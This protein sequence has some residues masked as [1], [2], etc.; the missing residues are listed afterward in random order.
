MLNAQSFSNKKNLL[1][2]QYLFIG[3]IERYLKHSFIIQVAEWLCLNCQM[4]RAHNNAPVVP[5]KISAQ[6]QS[7]TKAGI[8][9]SLHQKDACSIDSTKNITNPLTAAPQTD[10][11]SEVIKK[12]EQQQINAPHDSPTSHKRQQ[13][14]SLKPQG[15]TL[16]MDKSGTKNQSGFFGFD[17]ARSRSP[18]PKPAA[19]AVTEKVL[20]F[21]T[22]FL[23]SASNMISSAV[24]DE[25]STTP[26][27]SRK[28]LSVSQSSV[29]SATP[30]SSRKG[31]AVSQ[32]LSTTLPTSNKDI[33][34]SQTSYKTGS[35]ASMPIT[36]RKGTNT[37][38]DITKKIKPSNEKAEEKKSQESQ[39]S[40][41]VSADSAA[42]D[43]SFQQLPKTCPL[44]MTDIK[45]GPPNYST[46]TECK[47]IVCTLCGFSPVPQETKVGLC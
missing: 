40:K 42:V 1:D 41:T 11:K 39:P 31:S 45:N 3:H 15:D 33:S 23:S 4:Q 8:A 6:L 47:S 35:S 30:P 38:Q 7:S 10:N 34:V 19:S 29:S 13:L 28:G 27:A 44:C 32:T 16:K 43:K 22:S 46:C 21:G 5:K 17:G 12:I 20:G 37:S 2:K 9:P 25:H 14:E 36:L 24:M 26:P 18:S